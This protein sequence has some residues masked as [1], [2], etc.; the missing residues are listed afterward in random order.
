MLLAM[1]F[2][3]IIITITNGLTVATTEPLAMQ[4]VTSVGADTA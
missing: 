3:I 1:I 4:L 2:A